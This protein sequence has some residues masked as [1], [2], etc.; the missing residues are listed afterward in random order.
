MFLERL[1]RLGARGYRLELAL[2]ALAIAV[3]WAG[4]T[5]AV[6]ATL[7]LYWGWI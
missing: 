3:A 1:Y 4:I 2:I 7:R 6:N 5:I